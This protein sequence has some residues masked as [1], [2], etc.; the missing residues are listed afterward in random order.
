MDR[1]AL[2]FDLSC[3]PAYD[4]WFSN[5]MREALAGLENG[6][7]FEIGE[8]EWKRIADL[9]R[10]ELSRLATDTTGR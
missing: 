9:K 3:R 5:K 2:S 4:R 8:T 6:S 7:N 1:R 10:A